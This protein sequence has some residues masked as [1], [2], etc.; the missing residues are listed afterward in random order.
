MHPRHRTTTGLAIALTAG[1]G[2]FVGCDQEPTS[3]YQYPQPPSDTDS[4]NGTLDA[5][6]M[7]S[8][9]T[10]GNT[11]TMDAPAGRPDMGAND[12]AETADDPYSRT[13]DTDAQGR[14]GSADTPD[15]GNPMNTPPTSEP[16]GAGGAGGT[17]GTT[18]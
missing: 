4:L 8:P 5:N 6:G 13:G 12:R 9:T 10:P 3:T 15:S 17:G 2:V 18:P 1:L 11:G 7:D 16:Q 14:A